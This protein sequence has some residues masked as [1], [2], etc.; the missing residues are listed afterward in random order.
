[1]RVLM[2]S[3]AVLAIAAPAAVANLVQN[4]DFSTGDLTGW[5]TWFAGWGGAPNISVSAGQAVH[6]HADNNGSAGIYQFV[7]V[8]APLIGTMVTLDAQWEGSANNGWAE[9]LA[10]PVPNTGV[11]VNDAL[12]SGPN[13]GLAIR[14]KHEEND[15]GMPY[16]ENFSPARMLSAEAPASVLNPLTFMATQPYILLATKVGNASNYSIDN[17][18]LVPEPV[19]LLLAG[20]GGL[21][22]LPR[23]RRA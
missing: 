6:D 18:S 11:N 15:W 4:G 22:L 14:V 17:I 19:T 1:M 13:V 8:P 2:V 10:V 23:R 21:M 12:D 16:G 20:M 9:V 5:S 3:M 7:P